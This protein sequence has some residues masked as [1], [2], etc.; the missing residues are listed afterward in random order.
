MSDHYI[1]DVAG[2]RAV[3]GEAH[4]LVQ[5]KLLPSLDE[6]GRRFITAA[7]FAMLSTANRAGEPDVSP[8]GDGPGF[9]HIMDDTTLVLP[10]RPGNNLAYAMQSI[11]ENP[12]VALI[13]LIP[14][15]DETFRVHG[16]A[17]IS[18]D[19]GLLQVL[20]ARDRPALFAIEIHITKC[21]LHCGKAMK[22]SRLW[23][24]DARQKFSFRFGATIAR[25]SGGGAEVEAMVDQ[26]VESDYRENL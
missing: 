2:I 20:A 10:D 19:P 9:V 1:T 5:K 12:A 16:T 24:D 23:K 21:F 7:P 8:R 22:R 15:V 11:L 14:G 17:R 26:I 25:E 13:F 4:P 6:L 18:T 3:I